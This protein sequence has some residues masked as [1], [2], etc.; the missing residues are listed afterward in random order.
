MLELYKDSYVTLEET[1][2]YFENNFNETDTIRIHWEVLTDEEKE[3]YI[4]KSAREIDGL[5]LKGYKNIS[6]QKMAF[7]RFLPAYSLLNGNTVPEEVYEAQKLNI[8]GLI[9]KEYTT[10]ESKQFKVLQTLGATKNFKFN[11]RQSAE[12][13]TVEPSNEPLKRKQLLSSE[14]A[15]GLLSRW[16]RG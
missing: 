14:E 11:R 15:L 5:N 16:L 13:S 6:G 4:K 1:N 10:L 9:K 12:I 3:N 7:P 2:E 8:Y